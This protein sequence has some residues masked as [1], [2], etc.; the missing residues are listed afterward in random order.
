MFYDFLMFLVNALSRRTP[1]NVPFAVRDL[2]PIMGLDKPSVDLELYNDNR[3]VSYWLGNYTLRGEAPVIAATDTASEYPKPDF[4]WGIVHHTSLEGVEQE[5]QD[6]L[7]LDAAVSSMQPSE[8][9]LAF[10]GIALAINMV[11]QERIAN[12]AEILP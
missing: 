4:Y 9:E 12:L 2:I 8:F 10:K 7:C 3:Y 11:V 6:L 1:N 5:K